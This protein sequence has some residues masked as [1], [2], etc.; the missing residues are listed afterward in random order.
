LGPQAGFS[1]QDNLELFYLFSLC[2]LNLARVRTCRVFR[3]GFSIAFTWLSL[4]SL[5]IGAWLAF[6]NFLGQ[7]RRVSK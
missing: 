1:L 5:K 4:K 3:I 2:R 6:L 7:T